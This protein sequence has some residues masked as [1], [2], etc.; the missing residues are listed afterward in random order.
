MKEVFICGV[1]GMHLVTHVPLCE[2]KIESSQMPWLSLIPLPSG[3]GR[4][5]M[6]R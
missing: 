6:L 1:Q 3:A 2:L 5:G 4:G